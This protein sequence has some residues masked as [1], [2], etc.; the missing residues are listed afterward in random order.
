MPMMKL[1]PYASPH[2]MDRFGYGLHSTHPNAN[3]LDE[4]S[5]ECIAVKTIEKM[6]DYV[7]Y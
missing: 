3:K 7:P 2:P 4:Q 1:K 5:F 6:N